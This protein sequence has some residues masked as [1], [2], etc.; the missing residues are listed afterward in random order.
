MI[1]CKLCGKTIE[2][3]RQAWKESV[4]W[5]SPNGAKAMTGAHSTGEF[6]HAECVS[7][8][9]LGISVEQEALL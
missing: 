3:P 7:L 9:K 5:V 8:L 4:G 6:A 2:S 1:V